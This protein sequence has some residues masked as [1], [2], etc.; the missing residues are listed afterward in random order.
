MSSAAIP[1]QVTSDQQRANLPASR[2]HRVGDDQEALAIAHELAA[3]FRPG[4]SLRDS[5]RQ[6]PFAEIEKYSV[7][8][9][10]ALTVPKKYGGPAVSIATLAEVTAIISEADSSIGQI[11]QNHYYM[12][13]VVRANGTAAQKQQIYELAL[14]GARLGNALSEVGTKTVGHYNTRIY[15]QAD[16]FIVSGRKYYSTGALFAH[17]IPIVA[18]DET[19]D[20]LLAIVRPD[21]PG[22]QV[23][24]DWESFGQRT[25][26]SGSTV[27]DNVRVQPEWVLPYEQSFRVP[28]AVG[29]VGQI[30]HA[31]VDLGIARAAIADLRDFLRSAGHAEGVTADPL[32]VSSYGDL[33]VQLHAA[34]ALLQRGGHVVDFLLADACESTLALASVAVAEAKAATTQIALLSTNQLFELGGV[35]TTAEALN[36]NRHWRNARAHTLHDPVRWKFMA[37]GNYYLNEVYPPRH[38]AL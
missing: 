35:K 1:S 22:V 25:T 5:H 33:V 4:A 21:A 2:A 29:P 8:G 16:H 3:H 13:E 11:P 20:L 28:T 10:W 18:R 24:D 23:I 12:L 19:D 7:S 30:I 36:L 14:S 32:A 27:L 6:L 38:G 34:E 15:R 9:L 37:V 17:Y 26:G 31:A